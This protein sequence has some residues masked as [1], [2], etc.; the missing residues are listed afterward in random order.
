MFKKR[1]GNFLGTIG[2]K[3]VITK[4]DLGVN[5]F[6]QDSIKYLRSIYI[7][8]RVKYY[9][10]SG[11][12]AINIDSDWL[13]LGA[14]IVATIEL[15]MYAEEKGLTLKMHYGYRKSNDCY[16]YYD[17][18][19]EDIINGDSSQD[20]DI[21]IR[22]TNIRSLYELNFEKN[23]NRLLNVQ[24]AHQLWSKHI[25]IKDKI[26]AEV[27]SFV[28]A[29]FKGYHVLGLHYRGTD[30][31]GEA[32]KVNLDFVLKVILETVSET[33]EKFDRLFISTDE[34]SCIEFFKKSRLPMEIVWR[35]DIY[36]SKDGNQ[37]HRDP[38]N[39]MSVV[40][41]EA[42]INCLL[43]SKCDLLI[44]TA[45]I[46]SDC[47]KI[48]NPGLNMIILNEP[49]SDNLTWWPATELNQ[50]YLYKPSEYP[51]RENHA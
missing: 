41:R 15:L 38:A 3:K 45:S 42:L 11:I 32:P 10:G 43:L 36:R 48:F 30:K 9:S 4:I 12:L 33:A 22:F 1:I 35:E 5:N 7:P 44:K 47:S 40:N 37:F 23:Y 26:A 28:D 13:G 19:F 46:L 51:I 24:L 16:N 17:D 14:R 29:N 20:K 21:T 25:R 6:Y 31:S 50:K 39:D 8:K 2:L 34:S 49:H 18:L 27:N